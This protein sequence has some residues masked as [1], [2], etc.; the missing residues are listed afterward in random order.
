MKK[1]EM[2]LMAELDMN[3]F[4]RQTLNQDHVLYLAELI[5]NSVE[6]DAIKITPSRAVVDGRHR[7]EAH[8]LCNRTHIR[9][10]VVDYADE[11]AMIADAYRSNVGGSLPPTPQDTEHTIALLL[12]RGESKKRIGE[13]LGLP[14]GM[15]RRYVDSVQS[16]ISR[17]KLQ[18]ALDAISN[19]GLTL[20]KAAEQYGVDPAKLKEVLTGQRKK[21]RQGVGEIQ[22]RISN[23]YRSMSLKNARLI[24]NLFE[25]HEEGDVSDKQVVSIFDHLEKLQKR[26]ARSLADWRQRFDAMHGKTD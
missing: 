6:L 1:Y 3:L 16:K 19:A 24:M 2:V 10:E 4:V 15:A 22:R 14:A 20:A 5:E 23:L 13:L 12:E 18:R 25:K 17:Q 8:E 9:A 7:I 21:Q 26:S 11:A